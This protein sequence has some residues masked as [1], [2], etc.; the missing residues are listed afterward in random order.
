MASSDGYDSG[1]GGFDFEH[2]IKLVNWL[3]W[4]VQM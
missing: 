3:Y 2:Q 1:R 4:G